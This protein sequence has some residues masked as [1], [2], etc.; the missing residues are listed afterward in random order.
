MYSTF[1]LCDSLINRSIYQVSFGSF[2]EDVF[3]F[4]NIPLFLFHTGTRKALTK[5]ALGTSSSSVTLHTWLFYPRSS[6][7]NQSLC[8]LREQFRRTKA[9]VWGRGGMRV[10]TPRTG[11]SHPS[12]SISSIVGIRRALPPLLS[13]IWHFS[14]PP[15]PPFVCSISLL[16]FRPRE[17]RPR[18]HSLWPMA[19]SVF[20]RLPC[21]SGSG[22]PEI[23]KEWMEASDG[24]GGCSN[25]GGICGRLNI[26]R[27]LPPLLSSASL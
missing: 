14:L 18:H 6:R 16:I 11:V 12:V 9:R 25:A 17:R 10:G 5:K 26:D 22:K 2:V 8:L 15:P 20:E 27:W 21:K 13:I 1:V 23:N 3:L 19:R 7:V 24:R 4:N